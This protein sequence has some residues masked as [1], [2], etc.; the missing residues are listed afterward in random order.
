MI[1]TDIA[2]F[3][4][5][6]SKVFIDGSFA[7]VLYK[8]ELR[9]YSL[10]PDREITAEVYEEIMTTILPKRAK[11]RSMKLLQNKDYTEK[12]LRDKLKQGGYP[13]EVIEEAV[14]YV[15]SYRYIDDDR[16][17]A[18]YIEYHIE[19]KSKQCIMQELLKRGISREDAESQWNRLE[20]MGVKGD[21]EEMI[22]AVLEKKHYF[23]KRADIKEQRRMYAFLMRRGFSAEL[24]RKIMNAELL[25]QS[26][27][28]Y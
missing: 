13:Q 4:K 14:S 28:V 10:E 19:T 11:M 20:L 24:V 6:R 8:G 18:A 22:R 15:K 1:V 16:Y 23:E 12:Q 26:E 25:P 5:S 27:E 2:E 3:T 17:A 9:R 21:E 7:F